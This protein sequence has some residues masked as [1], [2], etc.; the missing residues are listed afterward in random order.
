[1]NID[2]P[3]FSLKWFRCFDKEYHRCSPIHRTCNIRFHSDIARGGGD[4]REL[5]ARKIAYRERNERS[6]KCRVMYRACSGWE[7]ERNKNA[8]WVF[9]EGF[10]G[11]PTGITTTPWRFRGGCGI[12]QGGP[13]PP[14][15]RAFYDG[16]SRA[17]PGTPI[18]FLPVVLPARVLLT[19]S[20]HHR[21]TR[22]IQSIYIW[23]MYILGNFWCAGKKFL[24]LSDELFA[25]IFCARNFWQRA[26]QS[27]E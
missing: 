12:F 5:R 6:G 10:H 21:G 3:T 8:P 19:C 13:A 23:S 16:S 25:A 4:Y 1:M 22:T 9:K 26:I 15:N 14:L 17:L 20:L 24:A 2:L 27:F 18:S 7:K 11:G